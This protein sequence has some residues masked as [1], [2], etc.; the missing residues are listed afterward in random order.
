MDEGVSEPFGGEKEQVVLLDA[1]GHERARLEPSRR[2]AS[3][4]PDWG[5]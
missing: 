3:H 2:H 5:R 1:A 4:S